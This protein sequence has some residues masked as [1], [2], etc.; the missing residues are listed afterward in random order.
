ML[1]RRQAITWVSDDQDVCRHIASLGPISETISNTRTHSRHLDEI[2]VT[3]CTLNYHCDN[4]QYSQCRKFRKKNDIS[5]R[6]V[7]RI[8]VQ[9][10]VA[11]WHVL[12]LLSNPLVPY[13]V[14]C[15]VNKTRSMFCEILPWE[16][17][18]GCLV[19]LWVQTRFVFFV[20]V[21]VHSAA[22]NII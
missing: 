18:M 22:C 3:G 7:T 14:Q 12:V 9:T 8:V 15:G 13:Q 1:N 21:T 6:G 16:Q 20:S 4:L 11:R 17:G 5:V 2:C 10:M 19:L